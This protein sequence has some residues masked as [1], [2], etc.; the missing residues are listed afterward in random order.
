[1][2]PIGSLLQSMRTLSPGTPRLTWYGPDGERIEL[3]GKVLDNWVAKSANFLTE[4]FD[5]AV[6]SLI[7]LQLP[8][9]WKSLCIAL[10]GLACGSTVRFTEES[11]PHSAASVWF[12]AEEATVRAAAQHLDTV[13]VA[14][15]ALAMAWPTE[16]PDEVE[17][18]DYAADVRMFADAF[19]SFDDP[20]PEDIALESAS[21]KLRYG[22]IGE[23]AQ[24]SK[25]PDDQQA[26]SRVALYATE[27]LAD[28][29]PQ[30]LGVWLSGGSVVLFAEPS[31]ASEKV[32]QTEQVTR[33][34]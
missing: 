11:D 15:P 29:V 12:A 2:N 33:L 26:E 7:V 27:G 4:E 34:G 10:A 5:V 8:A 32:L 6:G 1:M 9:H 22:Q 31:L 21:G 30:A 14:L 19:V 18:R 24:S 17:V 16:L 23:L 25:L 3:S 13:A 20:E 28:V